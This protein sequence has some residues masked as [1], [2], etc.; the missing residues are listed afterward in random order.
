[1]P[2]T[3]PGRIERGRQALVEI[4]ESLSL[5]VA[6]HFTNLETNLV[7]DRINRTEQVIRRWTRA[8]PETHIFQERLAPVPRSRSPG[9]SG[10][11]RGNARQARPRRSTPKNGSPARNV[12]T[13]RA[14]FDE[15]V[16][17]GADLWNDHEFE[18]FQ[19]WLRESRRRGE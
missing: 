19:A 4:R 14:Q 6:R 5:P 8:K 17:R 1:M 2:T 10:V 3:F 11:Q 18:R 13:S 7:A 12:K 15:L 16:G 9:S